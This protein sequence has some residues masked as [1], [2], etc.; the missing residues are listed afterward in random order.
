MRP[1][2]LPRPMRRSPPEAERSRCHQR[3][4]A[5]PRCWIERCQ[6]VR[7]A[8]ASRNHS[9]VCF[10]TRE[11]AARRGVFHLPGIRSPAPPR[12]RFRGLRAA[13]SSASFHP[14]AIAG[15]E[16]PGGAGPAP[17]RP[18]RVSPISRR[19]GWCVSGSRSP[20][21]NRPRLQQGVH[22]SDPAN[23]QGVDPAQSPT[24][25]HGVH[26]LALKG[27]MRQGDCGPAAQEP[28]R[29]PANE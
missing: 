14:A 15:I 26:S 19:R 5:A 27:V 25:R 17:L 7:A 3:D 9:D 21:C 18:H 23:G 29:A 11:A 10:A 16:P 24:S 2:P 1:P 12:I 20:C 8:R 22:N 4:R 6:R 28:A 13:A